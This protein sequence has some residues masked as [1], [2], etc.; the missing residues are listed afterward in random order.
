MTSHSLVPKAAGKV[1]IDFPAL[2]WKVLE[3]SFKEGR[4]R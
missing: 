2:C 1:G 4:P 3:T